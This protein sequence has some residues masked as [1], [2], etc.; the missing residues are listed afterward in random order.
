MYKVFDFKNSVLWLHLAKDLWYDFNS[1]V[2][3]TYVLG[4]TIKKC[5]G[6]KAYAF[7]LFNFKAIYL[8]LN[9]NQNSN[10]ING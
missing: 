8:I 2:Q 5:D 10:Q 3:T 6:Y 7:Y 9:E 4:I 1:E